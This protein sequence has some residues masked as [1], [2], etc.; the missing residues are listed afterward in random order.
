[1]AREGRPDVLGPLPDDPIE[2]IAAPQAI[3]QLSEV[4]GL[5]VLTTVGKRAGLG[6][7]GGMP[8]EVD[9]LQVGV[10]DVGTRTGPLDLWPILPAGDGHHDPAQPRDI[11]AQILQGAFGWAII[12]ESVQQDVNRDGTASG[13]GQRGQGHTLLRGPQNVGVLAVP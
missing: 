5:L 10:E 8:V 6:G 2:R 12:P 7:E 4:Q 3:G 1:M 13:Q 9:G 11:G